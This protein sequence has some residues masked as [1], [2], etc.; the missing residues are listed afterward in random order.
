M[1]GKSKSVIALIAL[2]SGLG[3]S[4]AV[5]NRTAAGILASQTERTYI[6]Q[7]DDNSGD[8]NRLQST[9]ATVL[10]RQVEFDT[11]YSHALTGASLELTA[12]EAQILDSVPGLTVGPNV[13]YAYPQV[14]VSERVV[15]DPAELEHAN[16]TQETIHTDYSEY[17]NAGK[18]I[19]IGILDTGLFYDQIATSTSS[20]GYEAFRPLTAD[21]LGAT[22]YDQSDIETA[23]ATAGYG[24]QVRTLLKRYGAAQ[25]S[26]VKTEDYESLLLAAQAIGNEVGADE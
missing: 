21:E 19:K 9:V 22:S 14:E 17:E 26:A 5:E 10:G 18:G 25:L 8:L 13:T 11:T 7:L 15:T 12:Q 24:A 16:F 3:I 4:Q 20:T 23:K 1:I 2:F 6:V